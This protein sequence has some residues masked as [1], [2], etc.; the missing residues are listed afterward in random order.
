MVSHSGF[1][2]HESYQCPEC[3]VVDEV[4]FEDEGELQI[5]ILTCCDMIIVDTIEEVTA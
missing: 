3:H 1:G 5:T 4:C 2:W